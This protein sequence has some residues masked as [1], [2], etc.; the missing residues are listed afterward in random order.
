M[1]ENYGSAKIYRTKFETDYEE[2]YQRL[3]PRLNEFFNSDE[4]AIDPGLRGNN[5]ILQNG[6]S[7]LRYPKGR[8]PNS[9]PELNELIDFIKP[10]I[11]DFMNILEKPINNWNMNACWIMVYPRGSFIKE[12]AHS[13][14]DDAIT[15]IFY[16]KRPENSGDLFL[17]TDSSGSF[18]G[19]NDNS[20][21]DKGQG[22]I[23]KVETNQGDVIMHTGNIPHWTT[24]NNTD[25][26]KISVIIDISY[27]NA[28]YSTST[29]ADP[30]PFVLE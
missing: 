26:E 13:P 23:Y 14:E 5:T 28:L 8:Q 20:G 7:T 4:G 21:D 18:L 27:K 25:E 3:L 10:H 19:I 2:L 22:V 1:I 11:V 17:R 24:E 16:L 6:K 12:H 9:W 15:I 30:I 29:F